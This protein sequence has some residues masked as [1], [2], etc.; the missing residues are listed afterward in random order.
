MPA[1]AGM[2]LIRASLAV[3]ALPPEHIALAALAVEDAAEN[4]KQ[5]R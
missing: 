3:L 5:V 1:F 4:E 2:T